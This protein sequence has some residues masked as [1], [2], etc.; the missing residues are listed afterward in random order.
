MAHL[1][2]CFNDFDAFRD[3]YEANEYPPLATDRLRLQ[4]QKLRRRLMAGLV[5]VALLD[6]D[7][8][9]DDDLADLASLVSTVLK[10]RHMTLEQ[11]AD[12]TSRPIPPPRQRP[13]LLSDAG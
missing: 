6:P 3:A 7:D 4:A 12:S 1:P 11:L 13:L 8:Q 5:D 2:E 9:Y 10:S